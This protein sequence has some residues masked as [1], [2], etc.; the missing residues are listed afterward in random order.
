MAFTFV[1][2]KYF[3]PMLMAQQSTPDDS[4]PEMAVRCGWGF[5]RYGTCRKHRSTSLHYRRTSVTCETGIGIRMGVL[6]MRI[7]ICRSAHKPPAS[8]R[9]CS[10]YN[11]HYYKQWILTVEKNS[12]SIRNLLHAQTFDTD[13]NFE[14]TENFSFRTQGIFWVIMDGYESILQFPSRFTEYERQPPNIFG[15]K[16]CR[17]TDPTSSSYV[18]LSSLFKGS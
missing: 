11:Y 6:R 8:T 18:H 1:Q 9:A 7:V 14:D 3:I 15:Y 16:G 12:T 13:A 2:N 5:V 4:S 10:K 17:L